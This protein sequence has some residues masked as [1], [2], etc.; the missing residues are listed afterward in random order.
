M[1]P[2]LVQPAA[3]SCSEIFKGQTHASWKSQVIVPKNV[4]KAY[5]FFHIPV[6]PINSFKNLVG[7]IYQCMIFRSWVAQKEGKNSKKGNVKKQSNCFMQ[8]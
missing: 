7:K 5:F 8:K 6:E 4:L 1:M 3:V 2:S